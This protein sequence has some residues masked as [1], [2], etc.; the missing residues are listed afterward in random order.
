M[1]DINSTISIITFSVNGLKMN[2]RKTGKTT[3]NMWDKVKKSNKCV[4]GVP[5]EQKIERDR[6]WIWRNSGRT[7]SKTDERYQTTDSINSSNHRQDKYK[8][9]HSWAHHDQTAEKQRQREPKKHPEEKRYIILGEITI[10]MMVDLVTKTT[11]ARLQWNNIFS[12]CSKKNNW[13]TYNSTPSKNVFQKWKVNKTFWVKQKLR[14]YLITRH[15]P[16]EVLKRW[17]LPCWNQLL[18]INLWPSQ[19]SWAR[20]RASGFWK[21]SNFMVLN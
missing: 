19:E 4:I 7:F 9:N 11:E 20:I 3:G 1:A 13:S 2:G 17:S 21:V 10:Q 18:G 6:I 12:K 5:E 15:I 16:Q 8:E 14:K